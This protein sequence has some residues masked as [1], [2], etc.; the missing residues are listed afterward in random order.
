MTSQAGSQAITIH[1]M[2]NISWSRKNHNEIW[3]VNRMK[4]MFFYKNHADNETG[5]LVPDLFFEKALQYQ[6]LSFNIFW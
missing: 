6:K 1:I 3:S 4:Q 5:K 2:P